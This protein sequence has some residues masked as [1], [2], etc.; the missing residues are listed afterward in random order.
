MKKNDLK[1]LFCLFLSL[2]IFSCSD[3]DTEIE[4]NDDV[5]N[6]EEDETE[7]VAETTL[8]ANYFVGIEAA[9]DPTIDILTPATSLD[10]GTISPVGNGIEQPAWMTFFQGENQ[11]IVGGYTSAPEFTS[12]AMVDG[13]LTEGES[14]FTSQTVYASTI[15]DESTMIMIGAPREGYADKN[16]YIIDTETMS[17]ATTVASDFGNDENNGYLAFPTDVNVTGDHMF[18]SYYYIAADGSFATPTEQNASVAVFTYPGLELEKIIED[19][20]APNIGRYYSLTGLEEDENGNI[21]TYSPSSLACGYAPVPT[22][23]SGILRIN[24][25]ETEFDADFYIDFE[26]LSGGYKLNDLYYVGNGK[27]VVR[28]LQEDEENADYLWAT[29]APNSSVP[30]LSYGILDLT[31][32]TY[33]A[34]SGAPLSGG[35]WDAAKYIEDGKLFVNISSATGASIYSIDPETATATEAAAI[36]GNYAK[37]ILQI[38]TEE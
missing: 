25:G 26:T 18:V 21:Y 36:E 34:V 6:V 35:G 12:Y 30:L 17:I 23:N 27:A 8:V 5:D 28:V 16:I 14:F 32:E 11:I 3:D 22:T 13:E 15:I 29:Y 37:G 24:N 2:A 31:T 38:T 10:E 20:R 4:V 19:E 1:L 7:E 9:T 33:T